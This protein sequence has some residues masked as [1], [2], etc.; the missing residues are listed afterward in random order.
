[1]NHA[2]RSLRRIAATGAAL[3]TVMLVAPAN[4]HAA[5]P[6]AAAA[7]PAAEPAPTTTRSKTPADTRD[8][9]A[10]SLG[11][12][13]ATL[14]LRQHFPTQYQSAQSHRLW[15]VRDAD[16]R[17]LHSGELE[18]SQQWSHAEEQLRGLQG[19]TPGPWKTL[20]LR[21]GAGQ[22]VELAVSEVEFGEPRR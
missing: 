20:R 10:A 12:D 4:T 1:M 3:S 14:L 5:A 9:S 16:G 7:Q 8:A 21:N 6:A 22:L 17:V 19:H 15:I 18:P 13:E 2:S 11:V